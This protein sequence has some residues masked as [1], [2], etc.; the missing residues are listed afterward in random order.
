MSYVHISLT[1]FGI[2]MLA[3]AALL[4]HHLAFGRPFVLLETAIGDAG[5]GVRINP[6]F[7]ADEFALYV[8]LLLVAVLAATLWPVTVAVL[9]FAGVFR[10]F[11]NKTDGWEH[12][13][14]E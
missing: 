13:I 4:G 1:V 2:L 8:M 7:G 6:G 12:E 3:W 5:F 14:A 10:T 9:V 11:A